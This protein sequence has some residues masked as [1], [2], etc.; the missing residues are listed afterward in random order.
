MKRNVV[1]L[2]SILLL[3]LCTNALEIVY[4]KKKEVTIGAKS[5]F[6]VGNTDVDAILT[7]NDKPIRIWENGVF[8]ENVD[9]VDGKNTFIIKSQKDEKVEIVVF[10]INKPVY[11]N[12]PAAQTPQ[13]DKNNEG[14]FTY[15]TIIEDNV[16]LRSADNNDAKRL[17]HL[18]KGSVVLID[19][20]KG[21][22]YKVYLDKNNCA[23]VHCKYV[24]PYETK[25]ERTLSQIDRIKIDEDKNYS[26]IKIKRDLNGAYTLNEDKN[27]IS[28]TLW[29]TKFDLKNIS[30]DKILIKQDSENNNTYIE[31]CPYGT[32]EK[33][34]GY[35]C[36]LDCDELIIKLRKE[37]KI[38][39]K[40][41]LEH[42]VIAIDAGHGGWDG[43]AIGPTWA[44]EKDINLD[45]AKRLE[46]HLTDAGA[47]VVMTRDCDKDVD[48]YERVKIAQDAEALFSIS[49]HANA[50]P[51][52]ANIYEKHG[53][54]VFYYHPQALEFAKTFKQQLTQ[55]LGTKD[56]GTNK[57]SFVLTRAT[58]PISI[59]VEVAYLIH[60][61][62][63][64]LLL[65]EDFREQ[66]AVSM[67]AAI[68]NYLLGK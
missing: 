43:G 57:A 5:T 55:D 49:I 14:E 32:S 28:V 51:D 67:K 35:D 52:G 61:I 63:Y 13:L 34:W 46:K 20:K 16:P 33:L 37:P 64:N 36:Y 66:A 8:A 29:G 60:P 56:D 54:S 4:P 19:G 53:T 45:I 3:G 26:Y 18:N 41:P 10:D 1:I 30:N 62:E 27:K 22:F 59:L 6:F 31:I 48:L 7:I 44:K 15:A 39:P 21:D 23:W 11:K 9:L 25:N 50:L 40:K 42:I 12:C 24:K 47:K 2:L 65:K 17:T 38:N 58:L 68:E